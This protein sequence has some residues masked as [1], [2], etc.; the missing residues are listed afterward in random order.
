MTEGSDSVPPTYIKHKYTEEWAL[1][2]HGFS[3]ALPQL[4]AMFLKQPVPDVIL[5][6]R[7]GEKNQKYSN[8][9]RSFTP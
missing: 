2:L 7:R 3:K 8:N 9:K 4:P 5:V 1:T 6:E